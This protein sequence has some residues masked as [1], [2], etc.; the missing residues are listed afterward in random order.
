VRSTTL[1]AHVQLLPQLKPRKSPWQAPLI[2]IQD[3]DLPATSSRRSSSC[4]TYVLGHSQG[5]MHTYK[6]V[7][8]LASTI[9]GFSR[10]LYGLPYVWLSPSW[11][12][13]CS[14][15]DVGVVQNLA[16]RCS[17]RP[18][19]AASDISTTLRLPLVLKH[20]NC[21]CNFMQLLWNNAGRLNQSVQG[22]QAVPPSSTEVALY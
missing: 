13:F 12:F 16:K 8:N 21:S 1:L 19:K 4:S 17:V 18:A 2:G 10:A 9:N 11:D 6:L 7:Q 3:L 20:T 15:Q 5:P 14:C 22:P